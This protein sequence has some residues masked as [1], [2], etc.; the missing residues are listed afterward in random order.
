M[1]S[2]T[3]D[4]ARAV[5]PLMLASR[6][7]S[8]RPLQF[9]RRLWLVRNLLAHPHG[10]PAK[11][12]Q[13]LMRA[14]P[15]HRVPARLRFRWDT[16]FTAASMSEFPLRRR[17]RPADSPW[18]SGEGLRRVCDH[19]FDPGHRQKPTRIRAG[20]SICVPL[21]FLPIFRREILPAIRE[22]FVLVSVQSDRDAP[23]LHRDLLDDARVQAWF[24]TNATVSHPRLHPVPLGLFD[25]MRSHRALAAAL[26]SPRTERDLGLVSACETA[27]HPERARALSLVSRL[28]EFVGF[29]R[30]PPRDYFALLQRSRFVLSA[31]GTGYDCYRTWE[32]LLCGAIPIV[33]SSPIDAVY[34][35]L[36]IWPVRDWDEIT[37]DS[38]Q[39]KYA[40][41][42]AQAWDL[43]VL[44]LDTWKARLAAHRAQL[45]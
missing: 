32:A 16:V 14:V 11:C 30:F 25:R 21:P 37:T 15:P 33:R 17:E 19:R 22:R 4:L 27:N 40:E 12:L 34:A 41:F 20:E 24:T 23:G 43:S 8:G 39:R 38:L 9:D 3:A 18:L 26:K 13:V 44:R 28:P 5:G 2:T 35:G 29:S 7:H 1:P 45:G 31:R 36:P 10:I 42:H 6:I